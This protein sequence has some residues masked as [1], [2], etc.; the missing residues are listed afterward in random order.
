M[1]LI[2]SLPVMKLLPVLAL[3]LLVSPAPGAKNQA[4]EAVKASGSTKEVYVYKILIMKDPKLD[5]LF[6][7]GPA[8]LKEHLEHLIQGV[9]QRYQ[10]LTKD[11]SKGI[12]VEIAGLCF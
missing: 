8:G 6:T 7:E 11:M 12:R 5:A 9:D 1:H 2:P 3:L 4:A 10:E